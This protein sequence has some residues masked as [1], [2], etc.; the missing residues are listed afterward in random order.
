MTLIYSDSKA[1]KNAVVAVEKSTKKLKAYHRKEE[2]TQLDI[3]KSFFIGDAVVRQDIVDS[4]IALCSLNISTQFSDNFDFQHRDDVIREILVNEEILLQNIHVDVLPSYEA[5]LC[6]TYVLLIIA[7]VLGLRYL[8]TSEHSHYG[9]MVLSLSSGQDGVSILINLTS[10]FQSLSDF[11]VS[12]ESCGFNALQG[13]IYVTVNKSD[14]GKLSPSGRSAKLIFKL[15]GSIFL[16]YSTYIGCGRSFSVSKQAFDVTLGLECD[17]DDTV[18]L[19]CAT[20][21]NG[22]KIGQL[23]P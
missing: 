6:V 21:G 20:I 13:N 23:S 8:V 2:P 19:R 18:V 14:N 12:M 1:V 17:I 11:E 9:K 15:M 5:A 7:L 16:R 22:T 4:G 3:D 10:H